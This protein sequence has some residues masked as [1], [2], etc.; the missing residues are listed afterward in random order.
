MVDQKSDN[1]R[2]LTGNHGGLRRGTAAAA[3]G[4]VLVLSAGVPAANAATPAWV[5]GAVS[6]DSSSADSESTDSLNR[7]T[8]LR[9]ADD[10]DTGAE[11]RT[12]TRLT[13]TVS[14]DA[15]D[16]E[17]WAAAALT[18]EQ[19][20]PVYP[21][22]TRSTASAL[23]EPAES[24][25]P[26]PEGPSLL[27]STTP[28]P[29]VPL[30]SRPSPS[31]TTAP[32]SEPEPSE[33]EPSEPGPSTTAPTTPAPSAEPSA[34]PES[35]ATSST[36]KSVPAPA[37]APLPTPR[38]A[39][40]AGT[41]APAPAGT[42]PSDAAPVPPNETSAAGT[43]AEAGSREKA[44]GAQAGSRAYG[45]SASGVWG[46]GELSGPMNM[47]SLGDRYAAAAPYSGAVLGASDEGSVSPLV[48]AGAVLVVVAGA[49]G[50]VAFRIRRSL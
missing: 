14:G 1:F 43:S 9:D 39:P 6:T 30:P 33:P 20:P 3:L 2:T 50:L 22:P 5:T 10:D 41:P 21:A 32:S 16:L 42:G 37:Q 34:T 17:A 19:D 23:A 7:V 49:A 12:G 47:A 26:L 45:R 40:A 18:G 44:S 24:L 48:W 38:Q 8:L 4:A 25:V 11:S 36:Q 31:T 28:S 15:A 46:S 27:S 29:S 13:A 35:G